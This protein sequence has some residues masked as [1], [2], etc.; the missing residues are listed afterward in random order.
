MR[1]DSRQLDDFAQEVRSF[2]RWATGADGTVMNVSVALC[3]ISSLYTAALHLPLPFTE[4]VAE[5]VEQVEPPSGSVDVVAARA[6]ELPLQIYWEVFDPIA[7]SPEEAVAGAIVDDLRDIYRDVA[8]RL[9][10]FQSGDR[11]EALGEWAFNFRIHWGQHAT[12]AL[13]A[14]HSYLAK[15]NPDGLSRD[16]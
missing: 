1:S 13:R 7:S 15:E 2:C 4:G 11:D 14:L 16:A 8:R 10:L 5:D 12:G 9:V 6:A 3:R